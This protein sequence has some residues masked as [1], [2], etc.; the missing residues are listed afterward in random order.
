MNMKTILKICAI[1]IGIG[2]VFTIIG[3]TLGG[4]NHSSIGI[5]EI[6]GNILGANEKHGDTKDLVDIDKDL[7]PFENIELN[8]ETSDIRIIPSDD[9]KIDIVYDKNESKIEYE[10]NDNT[11][12]LNQANIKKN[13]KTNGNDKEHIKIYVKE[14][15]ILQNVDID[16]NVANIKLKDLSVNNLSLNCNVGNIIIKDSIIENSLEA[17]SDVGNI[18]INGKLYGEVNIESKLGNIELKIDD[19]EEN[20]DYSIKNKLGVLSVNGEHHPRELNKI[21]NGKNNLTVE[22]KTGDIDVDFN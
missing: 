4:G 8:A 14:D 6:N 12:I 16:S 20:Y 21:N 11:L 3:Y 15:R 1:C 13:T 7:K 18:E 17:K 10:I 2:L 22:C 5:I 9:F 19:K